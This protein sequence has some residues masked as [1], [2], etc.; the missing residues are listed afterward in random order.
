MAPTPE[1]TPTRD[2]ARCG[3]EIPVTECR[4]SYC[5]GCRREQERAYR[6]ANPDAVRAR[7]ARYRAKSRVQKHE[8]WLN[9]PTWRARNKAY[10]E[11]NKHRWR[12]YSAR[13]RVAVAAG[14]VDARVIFERDH[15]LC[16]ICGAEVDPDRFD[17]DHVVPLS[18]G[19]VHGPENVQVAHP[20]CNKRKG[21]REDY[22]GA[23]S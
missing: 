7:H 17:I 8:K 3:V 15:G 9:D 13:R 5:A 6:A 18:R 10:Y 21:S 19:G 20:R 22:V 11:A 23:K 16:G 12:D 2:C 14:T 1:V 4:A